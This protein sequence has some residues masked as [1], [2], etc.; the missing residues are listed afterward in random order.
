[1][2]GLTALLFALCFFVTGSADAIVSDFEEFTLDGESFYNGSDGA[3]G[4]QS[5]DAFFNNYYNSDYGSW[6][7]FAYSNITDTETRGFLNQYSAITGSGV[8]GSQNYA[9]SY[10]GFMEP[11]TITFTDPTSVTGAYFTNTTYAYWSMKEG[12]AFSKKFGTPV[13]ANG[14]IDGTGGKDWYLLTITGKDS[15]GATT[16]TVDF[17]LADFRSD[18]DTKHY[19]INQWT[20]VD[21]SGLGE[22]QTLEFSLSSSDMGDWGINTPAYFAMDDLNGFPFPQD[23]D[24]DGDGIPDN[25]EVDPSLDLN[26]DGIPDSNQPETIKSL[27]TAVGDTFMGL[28]IENS[29]DVSEITKCRAMD[30]GMISDNVKRP[31]STPLGLLDFTLKVVPGARVN[32]DVIFDK[33]FEDSAKWFKWDE[34]NGWTD[35]SA[36]GLATFGTTP[37]GNTV[38]TLILEDGGDGD[39]DGALN[40]FISDPGGISG[41]LATSTS[42]TTAPSAGGG[43]GGCFISTCASDSPAG[44]V[45]PF[46]LILLLMAFLS[47]YKGLNLYKKK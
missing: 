37:K 14:E 8:D 12:D 1:M 22:V 25:Q 11:P 9:V 42:A 3:G 2:K 34:T 33:K 27:R 38:V 43:G 41:Q 35:Y 6:D 7:G 15:A 47:C 23:A 36:L 29:P 24:L 17:Y 5:G 4:F 16:G 26:N 39:A 30:Q 44:M 45:T 40:G 31:S 46:H 10:E 28:S 21:L 20:R 32:V 18:D 19:I 13:D